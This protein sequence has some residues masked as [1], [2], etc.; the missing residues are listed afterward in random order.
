MGESQEA[1]QIRDTAFTAL[2]EWMADFYLVAKRMLKDK[3]RW[4]EK[5]GI[6]QK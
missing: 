5:L 6:R 1:T 4:L 3:P 2:E